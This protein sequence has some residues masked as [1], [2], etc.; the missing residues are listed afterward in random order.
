MLQRKVLR[1]R[2]VR[3]LAHR[4]L[5]LAAA[6]A[7]VDGS[8]ERDRPSRTS[9]ARHVVNR[10]WSISSGG[11]RRSETEAPR[12]RHRVI[13]RAD[14]DIIGI[15]EGGNNREFTRCYV[16]SSTRREE[17]DLQYGVVSI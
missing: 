12:V 1:G 2:R 11:V 8:A 17:F 4:R 14:V 10:S 16:A 15:V 6:R 13:P 9:R 3:T 7:V 5:H